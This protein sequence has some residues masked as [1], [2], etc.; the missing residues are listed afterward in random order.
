MFL[1]VSNGWTN[2]HPMGLVVKRSNI[3]C[4]ESPSRSPVGEWGDLVEDVVSSNEYSLR[5]ERS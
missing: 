3:A 5:G 2:C 4:R 1:A